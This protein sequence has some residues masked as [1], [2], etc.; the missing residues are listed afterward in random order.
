MKYETF[1]N[2]SLMYGKKDKSP[3][4][5][6]I[7]LPC[8][9]NQLSLKL[10]FVANDDQKAKEYIEEMIKKWKISLQFPVQIAEENSSD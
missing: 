6:D 3:D 2:I 1:V 9:T 4:G 7:L 5:I 8:G 10:N